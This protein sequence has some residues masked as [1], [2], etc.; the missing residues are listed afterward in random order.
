M[1]RL[2]RCIEPEGYYH[3]IS[4]SINNEWILHDD[5]D[6]KHFRQLV[7][8]AK[9]KHPIRVFHYVFMNTHFHFVLQAFSKEA[10]ALN[11]RWVKLSYTQWVNQKYGHKGP[12]WRE[13]YK[14]LGIENESYLLACGTYVEYNPVRAGIC[15]SPQL[16]S[17]SSAAKYLL[18]RPDDLVDDYDEVES[19][20][21]IAFD[22]LSLEARKTFSQAKAVGSPLF[23]ARCR[24]LKQNKTTHL[25][26]KGPG[27][28]SPIH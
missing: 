24:F 21:P 4:R 26:P 17:Y 7:S 3:I 1:P 10:L 5:Q 20:K 23:I 28:S 8:V 9:R 15:Q 18:N 2:P 13:R 11:L 22:P 16:Y 6:F 12:V 25:S 19:L 14:S 27:P